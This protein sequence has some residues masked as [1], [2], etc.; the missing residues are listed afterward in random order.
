ML[1]RIGR[2]RIPRRD[3]RLLILVGVGAV[4]YAASILGLFGPRWL[5]AL[6]KG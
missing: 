2:H 1:R 3:R 6:V 4:V 5:K